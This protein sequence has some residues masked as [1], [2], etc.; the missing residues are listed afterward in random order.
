MK[1]KYCLP[2]IKNNKEEVSKMLKENHD[3]DF[4]EIWL[5]YIEDLDEKFVKEL[6]HVFDGKL[7]FLFRRK[8]LEEIKMNP[9]KR[10]KFISLIAR[11]KCYVDLDIINQKD[12]LD[13]IRKKNI[14]VLKIVSFHNYKLTP[15]TEIL[16]EV[17]KEIL[18]HHPI[19]IKV[20]TFCNRDTDAL[21]LMIL[22]LDLKLEKQGFIV[23]G[24]GDRGKITRIYGLIH[25]NAMNFAPV[26]RDEESAPGQF[27]RKELEEISKIIN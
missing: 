5:D 4:F 14:D 15:K 10:N 23:L 12:E 13:Y 1:I 22:M 11:S 17:I 20:A 8:K 7:I 24:M 19:V 9:E 3:Y 21:R 25:G 27:T 6:M 2:I 18:K 16:D 26:T